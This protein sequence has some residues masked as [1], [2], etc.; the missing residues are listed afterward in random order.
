MQ[1]QQQEK[2]LEHVAGVPAMPSFAQPATSSSTVDFLII[3]NILLMTVLLVGG[4]VA[5]HHAHSSLYAASH[6]LDQFSKMVDHPEMLASL[7]SS[8]ASSWMAGKLNGSIALF[9]QNL[10]TTNFSTFATQAN[11]YSSKLVTA[12]T[13]SPPP[14]SCYSPVTCQQSYS[15]I[16]CSNGKSVYCWYEG[17]V[18]NCANQTC[19]AGHVMSIASMVAAISANIMPYNG[20]STTPNS[21][22]A[23]SDGMFNVGNV[24]PW[25]ADQMNIQR[26]QQLGV[27]CKQVTLAVKRLRFDG[28]YVDQDGTQQIYNSTADVWQGVGYVDQI[29]DDLV[30]LQPTSS[31]NRKSARRR[32]RQ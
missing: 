15:Y 12:F 3:F 1:D 7:A 6:S 24:I 9:A 13:N 21:D 32:H 18:M 17:Q 29:C 10:L 22:A 4:A 23:F 19:I 2:S 16:Q 26:W 14:A 8:A 20:P 5:V 25:I 11:A 31:L 27:V 28:V 30:T